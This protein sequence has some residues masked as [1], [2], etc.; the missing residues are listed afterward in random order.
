MSAQQRINAAVKEATGSE[1]RRLVWRQRTDNHPCGVLGPHV[2]IA[3][4]RCRLVRVAQR[5]EALGALPDVRTAGGRVRV[6][7]LRREAR[8]ADAAAEEGR[9]GVGVVGDGAVVGDAG[10]EGG[11]LRERGDTKQG[12]QRQGGARIISKI[13]R[14]GGSASVPAAADREQQQVLLA[15]AGKKQRIARKE[16]LRA[17]L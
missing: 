7:T 2:V 5:A 11:L 15:G 1:M 4:R 13:R 9:H 6:R 16:R 3:E 14:R 17:L 10:G 12:P 8:R